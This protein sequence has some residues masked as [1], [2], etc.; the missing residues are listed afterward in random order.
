MPAVLV[1]R[2]KDVPELMSRRT[3]PVW[4]VS[5]AVQTYDD[6]ELK[7][8]EPERVTVAELLLMVAVP[9][10]QCWDVF[11]VPEAL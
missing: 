10:T 3:A 1:T 11:S 4:E 8:A 5:V 6:D 7:A 2:P 9:V